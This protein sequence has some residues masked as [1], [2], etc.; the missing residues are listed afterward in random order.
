MRSVI[1]CSAFLVESKNNNFVKNLAQRA[2]FSHILHFSSLAQVEQQAKQTPICFFLFGQIDNFSK[3]SEILRPIRICKRHNVRFFPI[4]HLCDNPSSEIIKQSIANGFDDIIASPINDETINRRLRKHLN[5]MA[6]Y[7]ETAR[8]FGPDRRR[9]VENNQ[10]KRAPAR[11]I[12]K[13]MQYSFIRD[14]KTGVKIVNKVIE[15]A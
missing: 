11:G 2:G 12:E 14:P 8:F 3:V 5:N 15:A 13:C 4:I 1:E 6:I 9:I 7:Y 10:I